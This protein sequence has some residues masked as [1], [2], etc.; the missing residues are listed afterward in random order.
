MDSSCGVNHGERCTKIKT[1]K[2]MVCVDSDMIAKGMKKPPR[3]DVEISKYGDE[4]EGKRRG[5]YK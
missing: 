4:K 2:N 1:V 3:N 5:D